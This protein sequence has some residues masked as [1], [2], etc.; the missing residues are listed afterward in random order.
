M[1]RAL[2]AVARAELTAQDAIAWWDTATR[3]GTPV[4]FGFSARAA[5]WWQVTGGVPMTRA[6]AAD[7]TG[8]YELVCFDGDRELR[9]R[10]EQDGRGTAVVLADLPELLPPGEH[11]VSPENAT[12]LGDPQPRILAGHVYPV[13]GSG[14]VR[15]T[16]AR[17]APVEVPVTTAPDLDLDAKNKDAPVVVLDSVE[18]VEQDRHGNVSVV[19]RRLVRLRALRHEELRLD[20]IRED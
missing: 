18:Y 19:D 13:D 11:D 1:S 3:G 6:G 20:L 15:L 2:R 5:T 12:P 14:W 7:L 9:W 17:Y 4:G 10:N 16:A 8:V